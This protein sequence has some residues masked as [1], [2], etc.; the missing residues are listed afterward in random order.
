MNLP[1]GDAGASYPAYRRVC[2]LCEHC[3]M[4]TLAHLIRPTG[5]YAGCVNIVG[6]RCWRVLSGLQAGV[7]IV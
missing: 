2:G 4:A 1:D 5:G 3:R 7:R 6:W